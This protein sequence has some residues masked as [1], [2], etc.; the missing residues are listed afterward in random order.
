M[1]KFRIREFQPQDKESVFSIWA[2]NQDLASGFAFVAETDASI[3]HEFYK[4]YF[5]APAP[6]FLVAETLESKEI[7]GWASVLNFIHNPILKRF[8]GEASIYLDRYYMDAEI[9]TALI[10]EA[11]LKASTT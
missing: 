9:G 4:N 2:M 11:F 5:S 8:I 1:E 7:L 10:K 6:V 3:E